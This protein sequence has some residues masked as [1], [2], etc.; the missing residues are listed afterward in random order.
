MH[1]W[2]CIMTPDPILEVVYDPQSR[3]FKS[4]FRSESSGEHSG[5][6]RASVSSRE[7]WSCS[8]DINDRASW[9][10]RDRPRISEPPRQGQGLHS[11][12][13]SFL[14]L[15]AR[16][17]TICHG[18]LGYDPLC[19]TLFSSQAELAL[20]HNGIRAILFSKQPK[21][22]TLSASVYWWKHVDVDNRIER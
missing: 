21:N 8:C 17:H 19:T 18:L 4:R 14:P 1:F 13:V 10:V 2:K 16:G 9:G 3:G 22:V 12:F 7:H 6:S 15:F 11:K 5:G 20:L